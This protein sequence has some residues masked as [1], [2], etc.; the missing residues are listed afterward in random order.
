MLQL[1]LRKCNAEA[2]IV[3]SVILFVAHVSSA[4]A[5]SGYLEVYPQAW[6]L[7]NSRLPIFDR[8]LRLE[9]DLCVQAKGQRNAWTWHLLVSSDLVVESD[10]AS[11]AFA[12]I[13]LSSSWLLTCSCHETPRQ[14]RK[15][16]LAVSL[17]QGDEKLSVHLEDE[18][19]NSLN[20]ASAIDRKSE[21]EPSIARFKQSVFFQPKW[22]WL[23]ISTAISRLICMYF[24]R[25]LSSYTQ[26]A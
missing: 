1:R 5:D 20:Q 14:A 7:I 26:S 21:G 15:R 9:R 4:G 23:Q 19:S 24:R 12:L 3:P 17:V 22:S 8:W 11:D 6:C 25:I 13:N 10:L 18:V 2:M 16:C